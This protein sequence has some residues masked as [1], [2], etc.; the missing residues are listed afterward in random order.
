MILFLD[1]DGVLHPYGDCFRATDLFRNLPALEALLREFPDVR[2]VISSSWR[3]DG[4]DSLRKNF[5]E[6]IAARIVGVTAPTP[7][8]ADG[9]APAEREQEIVAWLEVNGGVEQAWVALDDADWQFPLHMY[10]LVACNADVGFDDAA[11]GELRSHFERVRVSTRVDLDQR[12]M[13]AAQFNETHREW[14]DA[15]NRDFERNG[16]WSDGISACGSARSPSVGAAPVG[17][18]SAK[19]LR[20]Q[21]APRG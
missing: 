18:V 6:D 1:F 13:D 3:T 10:R 4:L 19:R 5:S 14:L 17:K 11:C 15:Q 7:R 20:R 9:Y 21:P 8:S 16:L 2:I 12:A